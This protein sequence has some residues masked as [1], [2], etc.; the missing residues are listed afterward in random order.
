MTSTARLI[1]PPPKP[2]T[3]RSHRED[4]GLG[5]KGGNVLWAPSKIAL[6]RL[7]HFLVKLPILRSLPS[8]FWERSVLPNLVFTHFSKSV[9]TFFSVNTYLLLTAIALQAQIC[10]QLFNELRA[11]LLIFPIFVCWQ[12]LIARNV[13]ELSSFK[14]GVSHLNKAWRINKLSRGS[15]LSYEIFANN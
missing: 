8:H 5:W 9:N 4:T 7:K 13:A 12:Q 2:A 11:S 15:Y 14:R 6:A 3:S 1:P 10:A